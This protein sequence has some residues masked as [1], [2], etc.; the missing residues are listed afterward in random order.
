MLSYFLISICLDILEYQKLLKPIISN[1]DNY[2]V[3][4]QKI[5]KEAI[6]IST[7]VQQQDF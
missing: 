1:L 6:K 2:S 7:V 4:D 5:I 3:D